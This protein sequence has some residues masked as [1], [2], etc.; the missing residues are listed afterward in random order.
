[1]KQQSLAARAHPSTP[2]RGRQPG[3]HWGSPRPWHWAPLS[4]WGL[5]QG[6]GDTSRQNKDSSASAHHLSLAIPTSRKATYGETEAF[7][8]GIWSF[9]SKHTFISLQE[10]KQK[11]KKQKEKRNLSFLLSEATAHFFCFPDR[12][13]ATENQNIYSGIKIYEENPSFFEPKTLSGWNLDTAVMTSN[14]LI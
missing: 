6:S 2:A 11:K 3:G 12:I 1:M 5:R 4:C 10:Y 13:L 8:E 14:I 7:W 9:G